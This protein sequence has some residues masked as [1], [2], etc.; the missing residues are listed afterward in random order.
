MS[1]HLQTISILGCGWLGKITGSFLHKV[2]VSV[3]GSFH[4]DEES[5][6][7]KMLGIE[8]IHVDVDTNALTCD[9]ASFWDSDVLMIALPPKRIPDIEEVYPAMMEQ[10]IRRILKGKT[11]KVVFISSTS[12]YPEKGNEVDERSTEE[13]IKS[14]GKAL[15]E[16]EEMFLKNESLQTLILRAGGLIGP[17]RL[18]G[19][20][21]KKTSFLNRGNVPVNLVFG[22]DVAA[23]IHHVVLQDSWNEIYNVVAPSH[24]YRSELYTKA[25]ELQGMVIPELKSMAKTSRF[26]IVSCEKLIGTGFKFRYPE[27]MEGMLDLYNEGNKQI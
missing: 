27:L 22:E 15:R 14:S 19:N 26:K 6:K 16:V 2:N 20:F 8:P 24:P 21:T 13:A 17:G 10:L 23:A 18:P 11:R 3:L 12:V 1:T 5:S 9:D 4:T 7:L 25:A